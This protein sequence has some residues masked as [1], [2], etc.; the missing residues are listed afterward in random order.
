MAIVVKQH[1]GS[2]AVGAHGGRPEAALPGKEGRLLLLVGLDGALQVVDVALQQ[3]RGPVRD[4]ALRVRLHLPAPLP[5][6]DLRLQ[7]GR[8]LGANMPLSKLTSDG[9]QYRV[10]MDKCLYRYL[11]RL[12]FPQ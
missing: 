5:L 11:P 7:R 9:S 10:S 4:V 1:S 6:L 12:T 3:A 2:P 8:L